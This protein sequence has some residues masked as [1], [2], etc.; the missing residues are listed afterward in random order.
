MNCFALVGNFEF[1][2]FVVQNHAANGVSIHFL[3]SL[4]Q[5]R[6]DYEAFMV[7]GLKEANNR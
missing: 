1:G 7:V 6:V 5:C 2:C 3:G 4:P